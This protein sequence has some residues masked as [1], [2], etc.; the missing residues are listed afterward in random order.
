M[1]YQFDRD[2]VFISKKFESR[3]NFTPV[4]PREGIQQLIKSLAE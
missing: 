4:K 1:A 3:F 2:Y